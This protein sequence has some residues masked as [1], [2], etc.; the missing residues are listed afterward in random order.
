MKCQ[1][2]LIKPGFYCLHEA[3]VGVEV[4]GENPDTGK[5]MTKRAYI[6][7]KHLR[8]LEEGADSGDYTVKTIESVGEEG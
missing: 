6:C 8:A 4:S 3:K 7:G 1:L 2:W 5:N